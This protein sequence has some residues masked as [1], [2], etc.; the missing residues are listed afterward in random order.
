MVWAAFWR[1]LFVRVAQLGKIVAQNMESATPEHQ[2]TVNMDIEDSTTT[3]T[4]QQLTAVHNG[5]ATNTNHSL[6]GSQQLDTECLHLIFYRIQVLLQSF[7]Y[8][9]IFHLFKEF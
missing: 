5:E 3:K 4:E 8:L 2:V 7:S 6:Q 1:W 9:S